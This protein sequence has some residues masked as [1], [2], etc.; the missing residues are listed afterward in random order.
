MIQYILECIAFQLVFLII[1]DLFL[2]RETFFQWNRF[3]LICTFVLSLIIPWVKIEAMKANMPTVFQGYPEYLWYLDQAPL[4]V[5]Q[6]PASDGQLS[7]PYLL[8]Y[9]GM[10]LASLVFAYKLYQIEALK[11]NGKKQVFR[12]FTQYVIANSNAA[13]SFFKAIFL[14]DQVVGK[15]HQSIVRHELVHI[16]QKHSYDLL[17][18]ELMRIVGWF[19]PMVYLYQNRIS[20]LHEFIADAQVAKSHKKEQ[21]QLLLSEVFQTQNISFINQFFKSS[22]IKKRIVMLTKEKSKQVFKL[23]YFLLI[24]ILIGMLFYTSCDLDESKEREEEIESVMVVNDINNMSKA[25]DEKLFLTLKSLSDK[26]GDWNYVLKDEASSIFYEASHNGS[27]I[28][29]E[30]H[31]EKIYGTMFI[32]GTSKGKGTLVMKDADGTMISFG[33][34]DEVPIFPGCED[35]TDKRACFHKMM[36]EHISKNFRYP[37]KAQEMGIQ[38]RVNTMFI[39]AEDGSIQNL[40]MRGPDTLLEKEVAR[41]IQRLPK[42]Q[43]GKQN[44]EIVRVPFSIPIS[45]KL[46]QAG[47]SNFSSNGAKFDSE[48]NLS[49]IEYENAVPFAQVEKVPVFPG[50][51]NE[52]DKRACFNAMMQKH[53]AKNFIYPEE[54][55]VKGIQGRVN[56]QFLIDTDGNIASVAKRGPDKL[57]EDEVVRIISRLPKME[58][59]SHD[60]K[61]VNV[62]Y[63]I[64]VTFKLMGETN[65]NQKTPLSPMDPYPHVVID[66]KESTRKELEKID[67]D[68]INSINVL[69]NETA[70]VTYGSKGKNGVIEV[71]TKRKS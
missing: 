10:F 35:E 7:W 18:F 34:I 8:V 22:L 26:G 25:D 69:K 60:G 36:Q 68:E 3:Y 5:K 33:Q 67:P 16:R 24:P 14:G 54:A 49:D 66:G 59:G 61:K 12:D 58:S 37:Q 32:Q 9:L 29:F 62:P 53:I 1:Y 47:F 44:G 40:R 51:E 63:S 52:V 45:F 31:V 39:I 19:D 57:L 65:V 43:P 28:K 48:G 30:D 13:F 11:R 27:F 17:F 56:V 20:E 46:E 50:C 55:Q 15:E 6:A 42:M 23:K 2:K 70:I 38:G 4:V 71:K 41:I 64:P 21:Y